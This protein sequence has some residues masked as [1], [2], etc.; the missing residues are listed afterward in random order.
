MPR[1]PNAVKNLIPFVKGDPRINRKG[2]PKSARQ[3]KELA[4]EIANEL[5]P[6]RG[7]GKNESMDAEMISRVEAILRNWATSKNPKVQ[8]AFIDRAFGK[9]PDKT[10]LTGGEDEEDKNLTINVV[11]DEKPPADEGKDA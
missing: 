2:Q 1:N 3:L 4:V 11:F 10:V 5:I 8:A 6:V 7:N 9:V